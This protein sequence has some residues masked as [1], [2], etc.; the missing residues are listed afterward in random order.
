MNRS[1]LALPL[2]VL[3]ASGFGCQSRNN[4]AAQQPGYGPPPPQYA[5]PGYQ[6]PGYQ[7][8]APQ[9]PGYQP[10]PQQPYPQQPAPQQPYPQQPAPQQ[11][12]PQGQQPGGFP[13]PIPGIPGLPG[14][15]GGGGGGGGTQ[16][17][18]QQPGQP[19]PQ[20]GGGGSAQPLDPNVAQAA[21]VGLFP[22]VQQHARGMQKVAG[23]I[24]GNFQQ[25][26]TLSVD[27]QMQPGKCYTAVANSTG[28]GELD[29]QIVPMT[30]LGPG[31]AVAQDQGTGASAIIGASGQC[32]T[33]QAPFGATG[34][35]IMTARSGGG[36]AAAEIYAR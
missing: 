17:A 9:Q 24:A 35:L 10:A 34:R 11:P 3:A 21:T 19:A 31:P 27:F 29:L 8:P 32:W 26:Q 2:F 30:P 33:Y 23:P 22:L 13:F 7:Q 5:Q 14:F 4:T 20:G 18:P 28:I 1:L 15:P 16:P 25:G 36:L 12:A 6:Q